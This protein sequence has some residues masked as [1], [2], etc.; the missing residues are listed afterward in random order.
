MHKCDD[1]NEEGRRRKEKEGRKEGRRAKKKGGKVVLPFP[2]AWIEI[3]SGCLCVWRNVG[4]DMNAKE[5]RTDDGYGWLVSISFH[6]KESK[7]KQSKGVMPRHS[8]VR[9]TW[10]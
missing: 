3:V 1:P 7:A 10:K 6:P 4:W 5:Y 9:G 2:P 8:Y